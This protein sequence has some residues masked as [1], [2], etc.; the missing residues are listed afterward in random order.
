MAVFRYICVQEQALFTRLGSRKIVKM[1]FCMEACFMT[2]GIIVGII[3]KIVKGAPLIMTLCY[4][5]TYENYQI[6][7]ESHKLGKINIKTMK[8]QFMC[9]C[10]KCSTIII[11]SLRKVRK[12]LTLTFFMEY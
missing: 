12:A 5:M 2:L 8:F 6:F 4:G 7:F 11:F 1:I 9:P 3:L 10:H